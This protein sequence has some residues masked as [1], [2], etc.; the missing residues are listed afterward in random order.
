MF[1]GKSEGILGLKNATFYYFLSAQ[2]AVGTFFMNPR[3]EKIKLIFFKG[4]VLFC[5]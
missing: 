4:K 1:S 3:Y 2:V 5:D